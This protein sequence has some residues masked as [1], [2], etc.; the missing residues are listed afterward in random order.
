MVKSVKKNIYIYIALH[1]VIKDSILSEEEYRT[2]LA[3]IAAIINLRP[4]WSPSDGDIDQLIITCQD[5][6]RPS[7]LSHHP[8]AL[9]VDSNPKKRHQYVQRLVNEW[10]KLWL[11]HFVPNLQPRSKWFKVRESMEKGDVV[12][13]ID[14]NLK[15]GQWSGKNN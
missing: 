11:R 15:R 8:D 7:N 5:L 1:K 13:I 14:T 10:W 2:L 4:L 3:E 9:N 12:L 6:I